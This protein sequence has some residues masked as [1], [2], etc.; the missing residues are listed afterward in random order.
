MQLRP[1]W[2]GSTGSAPPEVGSTRG[3]A[4]TTGSFRSAAATWRSSHQPI[5]GRPR[6]I[7]RPDRHGQLAQHVEHLH[8]PAHNAAGDHLPGNV[9]KDRHRGRVRVNAQPDP[10]H[11]VRHGRRTPCVVAA[12]GPIL[13]L[14]NSAQCAGRRPTASLSRRPTPIWSDR[15]TGLLPG[16]DYA[17]R[18]ELRTRGDPPAAPRELR[19]AARERDPQEQ[20][21][22]CAAVGLG[23]THLLAQRLRMDPQIGSDVRDRPVGL[24]G[25]ANT[26][27]DQLVGTLPRSGHRVGRIAS[28]Q[29][30]ILASRSPSNSEDS[31][32]IRSSA[33]GNHRGG[34]PIGLGRVVWRKVFAV[35]GRV[36]GRM[37]GSDPVGT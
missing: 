31:D 11:S 9:V 8:R 34:I 26:A 2:R 20:R 36:E 28:L 24:Q 37:R 29:D 21:G 6:L 3:S 33:C 15:T 32:P 19:A 14:S 35:N 25:Q 23:P 27:R 1:G 5:A 16:T 10:T 30:S 7:D 13:D 22:A 17:C 18:P 12:E 4:P